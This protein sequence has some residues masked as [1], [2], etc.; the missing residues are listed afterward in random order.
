M[1]AIVHK[2]IQDIFDVYHKVIINSTYYPATPVD[3]LHARLTAVWFLQSDDVQLVEMGKAFLLKTSQAKDED[4][5]R[6]IKVAD[7]IHSWDA[8]QICSKYENTFGS[9]IEYKLSFTNKQNISETL[10]NHALFQNQEQGSCFISQTPPLIRVIG[11]AILHQPGIPFPTNCTAE[12]YAELMNQIEIAKAILIKTG[13]G[14]IA[15][16]QCATIKKPYQFVIVGV[17]YESKE[18]VEGAKMRY[19]NV[20]FP[21][22]MIML[23]PTIIASSKTLQHFNHGC[24][25]V[26][27]PN[28]CQ[29]QSPE[30]LTIQYQNPLDNMSL[31]NLSMNGIDA[32]V[33][34]H[35]LNHILGGKTYIDTALAALD[36][37]TLAKLENMLA[38]EQ[39]KRFIP[40]HPIPELTVPPFYLTV[41]IDAQGSSVLDIDKLQ[42]VLPKMTDETLAGLKTRCRWCRSNLVTSQDTGHDFFKNKE[43][44]EPKKGLDLL[45]PTSKL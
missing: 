22:A 36:S 18:H 23:N 9:F 5:A 41:A 42:E 25:S 27:S 30:E 14:G 3:T 2:S 29:I 19:P 37:K 6:L 33:L 44:V 15:A 17:F 26:P 4:L 20:T 16:N 43:Q 11:D 38:A 28:R 31:V 13:G 24:L 12:E 35:E 7:E 1:L 32:V 40:S 39:H 8:F 10:H 34:W 45:P 21:Q